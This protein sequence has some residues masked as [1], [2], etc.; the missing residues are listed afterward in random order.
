M[1]T[2]T[3]FTPG[4]G[5]EVMKAYILT[6]SYNDYDQHGEYFV[7]WFQEMPS[8]SQIVKTLESSKHGP[9][10]MDEAL[11]LIY[12]NSHGYQYKTF[13]LHEVTEMEGS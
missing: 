1:T 7:A 2:T 3:K 6:A 13:E 8:A 12:D 10:C 9:I 4:D 5:V 11:S